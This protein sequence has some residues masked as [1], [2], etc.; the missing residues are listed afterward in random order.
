MSDIKTKKVS[1]LPEATDTSGFWIFGSKTVNGVVSSVKFAFD[2]IASL[3][4]LTQEKGQS[5]TLAPSQKL[6]T[7]SQDE[8]DAEIQNIKEELIYQPGDDVEVT[9]ITGETTAGSYVNPV[10]NGVLVAGADYHYSGFLAVIPGQKIRVSGCFGY[11]P[12]KTDYIAGIAGYSAALQ[13]SFVANIFDASKAGNAT[14]GRWKVEKFIVIIPEGVNYVR[15]SSA[16]QNSGGNEMPL[17]IEL[18]TGESG[19]SLKDKVKELDEAINNSGR[20][21]ID[22]SGDIESGTLSESGQP[23]SAN[24]RLRTNRYY[25]MN[26]LEVQAI[27]DGYEYRLA[28]YRDGIFIDFNE[29]SALA[30]SW[31]LS[32]Y[33]DIKLVFRKSTNTAISVSEFSSVGFKA[34]ADNSS[35]SLRDDVISRN[36]EA[37]KAALAVRKRFY[38][39]GNAEEDFFPFFAHTSDL[40]G[41]AVR[42]ENFIKYCEHL[43]VDSAFV[44]GDI[45]NNLY[46]DDFDYYKS[47]ALASGVNMLHVMGNHENQSATTQTDA[48]QHARFFAPLIEKM[49]VIHESK[50]YYYKDFATK[51]I[52]VIALNEYQYGGSSRDARYLLSDQITWFINTLK[53][54]P[55]NYGVVV[56]MHQPCHIW[57]ADDNYNKFFQDQKMYSEIKTN[58]TGDPIADIVDAFISKTAINKSY[59]QRGSVTSITVD[60]DFSTVAAGVEF[61]A[62]CNGHL[63]GDYI[64]YLDSTV[65]KQLV[66]NVTCG[67]SLTGDWR[68][69]LGDIPRR[70]GTVVEDAFNIYGVNRDRKVVNIVR[71]GSNMNYKMEKRDFMSIPYK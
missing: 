35:T 15:G 24:T 43:G 26:K 70:K 6:F 53:S 11:N 40:H 3:F 63:H 28:Y 27:N 56:L 12:T 2:T 34:I 22:I 66:L 9:E 19:L 37:E 62:Y 71:I 52:R 25:Q 16:F 44:S 30:K 4:G 42:L 48:N 17:L 38:N 55:S 54:T 14:Q 67:I 41:D 64:G 20:S 57:S 65:N 68:D 49:N 36:K 8:Q 50:A 5:T 7:E 47:R 13:S 46:S 60:A 21:E 18:I 23:A 1:E 45:V 69:E 58:I 31:D 39:F 51:K 32:Q 33:S 61:I 10:K 59:T 29:W